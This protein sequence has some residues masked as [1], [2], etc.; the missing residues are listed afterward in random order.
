MAVSGIPS[1]RL[2]FIDPIKGRTTAQ[3]Q[4]FLD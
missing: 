3:Y 4:V 2:H 1:Q